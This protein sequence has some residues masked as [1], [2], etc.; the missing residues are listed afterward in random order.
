MVE[1]DRASKRWRRA[2]LLLL[3]VLTAAM[4]VQLAGGGR[5]PIDELRQLGMREA[6]LKRQLAEVTAEAD[7]PARAYCL[8][9]AA[10]AAAKLRL[11]RAL[12]AV[13]DRIRQ[14]ERAYDD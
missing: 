9:P 12:R 1:E 8:S 2:S 14:I 3:A 4:A 6:E 5:V 13:V 7:P 10:A 11:E